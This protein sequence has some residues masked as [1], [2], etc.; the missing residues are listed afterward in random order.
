MQR[1]RPSIEVGC[2]GVDHPERQKPE[3]PVNKQIDSKD[4]SYFE[5]HDGISFKLR[6]KVRAEWCKARA[7]HRREVSAPFPHIHHLNGSWEGKLPTRHNTE[8]R[9]SSHETSPQP[10][11]EEHAHVA[12]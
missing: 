5:C 11:D 1:E 10:T 4:A 2:M 3:A 12:S 9:R 7:F 6:F 8:R